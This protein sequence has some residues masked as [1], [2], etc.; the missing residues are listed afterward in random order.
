[1]LT[2]YCISFV[3][4]YLDSNELSVSTDS[5]LLLQY[6]QNGGIQWTT[7]YVIHLNR[8]PFQEVY[9][10]PIP[11]RATTSATRLRW[12]QVGEH[13]DGLTGGWLIDE[14]YKYSEII[15][16]YSMFKN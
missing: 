16:V 8:V 1:M 3:Q 15:N 4:F 12:W 10:I 2:I 9:Q 5:V 14:V 7:F 6:S 11:P 13:P